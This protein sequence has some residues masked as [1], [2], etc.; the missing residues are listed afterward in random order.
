MHYVVINVV[1]ASSFVFSIFMSVLQDMK[2][3]PAGQTTMV[4]SNRKIKFTDIVTTVITIFLFSCSTPVFSQN[5]LVFDHIT[6]TEGISQNVTCIYR[7]S[8]NFMWFGTLNGIYRYDGINV[9]EYL[10]S[11]VDTTALTN[12]SVR[13]I[14]EDS[15]NNLWIG[16]E[17]GLNIFNYAGEDFRR[18]YSTGGPEDNYVIGISEDKDG[19]LWVV[20]QKGINRYRP[21]TNDFEAAL[22]HSLPGSQAIKIEASTAAHADSLYFYSGK[23]VYLFNTSDNTISKVVTDLKVTEVNSVLVSD[24][25]EIWLGTEYDGAIRVDSKGRKTYFR[26]GLKPESGLKSVSVKSIDTDS[27]HNIWLSTRNGLYRL[28]SDHQTFTVFQNEYG[29]PG[30]LLSS[31]SICLYEDIQGIIWVSTVGGINKFNPESLRFRHYKTNGLPGRSVQGI[32]YSDD[33]LIWNFYRDNNGILWVGSMITNLSFIDFRHIDSETFKSAD[34]YVSGKKVKPSFNAVFGIQGDMNNNLWFSTD[35]GLHHYNT[36]TKNLRTF[37]HSETNANSIIN[38]TVGAIILYNDTCL[39]IGT[40]EGLSHFDINKNR[41]TNYFNT[42]GDS[43]S[44]IDNYIYALYIDRFDRLWVL[45]AGGISTADLRDAPDFNGKPFRFRNKLLTNN[46][47]DITVNDLILSGRSD[48]VIYWAASDNGFFCMDSTMA[49]LKTYSVPDGLPNKLVYQIR[50][51]ARGRLWLA[52]D[53]G[54]SCF[55]PDTEEFWNFTTSDGLQSNEF[56]SNASYIDKE[57]YFYFGGINGF[58]VFHPDSLARS[59]YSPRI[60]ISRLNIFNEP[61]EINREVKGFILKESISETRSIRLNYRQNFLSFEFSALDYSDPSKIQYQYM[62]EGFDEGW[63]SCRNMPVAQYTDVNPGDYVFMVRS[64]NSDGVW[65]DNTTTLNI[66]I[67]PPFWRTVPF[68]IICIALALAIIYFLYKLRVRSLERDKKRL[69]EEVE[70]RTEVINKINQDLIKS[71][72]FIESVI[73]NA[74]YGITV[75]TK[76]GNI[77]LAN[78]AAAL[79]TGYSQEELLQ[80]NYR[81]FTPEKWYGSDDKALS[82][83]EK[84]ESAYHE[85]EYIRKDGSIIQVAISNSFIKNYDIPAIV[86]IIN[87]ITER[88]ANEKELQRHRTGLETLVRERTADLMVAK[89]RAEKADRLKTAFLSNISHEIRTPMNAIVGFSNLLREETGVSG[90]MNEYVDYIVNGAQSLLSIVTNIVEISRISADDITISSDRF[91]VIRLIY[92]IYSRYLNSAG[93]K[94]L[95]L[96]LENKSALKEHY[97]MADRGKL[98]TIIDHLL[99]NAI[100]FTTKGSIVL[101]YTIFDDYFEVCIRDTGIGI[102]PEYQA[103]VFEP[104]RQADVNFTRAYGGTG[105]GLAISKAYIEK[106]GGKI[107]FESVY[108]EGTAFHFT[109][110]YARDSAGG[111]SETKPVAAAKE[112]NILIVEDEEINYHYLAQILKKKARNIFHARDGYSAI[113]QCRSNREINLVLMDIKLPGINGLETTAE[114]KKFRPDLPVI[115]QTAYTLVGDREKALMAGCNDYISKPINMEKLYEMLSKYVTTG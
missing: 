25:G 72:S 16:T 73:N 110:P 102:S 76:E 65:C 86:N 103:D 83:L 57:G 96:I 97:I 87:D 35:N 85:K 9:K 88:V 31:Y 10:S 115:A 93:T 70:K 94:G 105:L 61:V 90:Q 40:D 59:A 53:K 107:W 89:E 32:Y 69:E 84:G 1:F 55:N 18:V 34:F 29:N 8:R 17:N 27:R 75:I 22:P 21:Q 42:P 109:V 108:G 101:G 41:F 114:I 62:L 4:N 30:S 51:D 52:T 2:S 66:R 11:T 44:L 43:T 14:F 100:K 19:D 68:Y 99:D 106:M 46:E 71:N 48:K 113:E 26:P 45:T 47:G 60:V 33:N 20:T 15:H 91:N 12:G 78:P 58:N 111:G 82:K 92:D 63:I 38:N 23:S 50:E 56:N 37:L 104:F 77:I 36:K 64:T 49:I 39:W 3:G 67:V 54:L 81:D 24:G 13:V 95:D 28:N 112:L 7:D 98:M 5:N 6:V 79:L 80:M 74:T